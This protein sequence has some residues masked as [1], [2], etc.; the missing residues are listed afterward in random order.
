M[1]LT[2][3][4]GTYSVQPKLRG[5]QSGRPISELTRAVYRGQMLLLQDISQS[6]TIRQGTKNKSVG[7]VWSSQIMLCK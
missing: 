2:V 6:E 3:V 7:E 1:S 5:L 4:F